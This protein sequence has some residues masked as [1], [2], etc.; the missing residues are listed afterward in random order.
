[1]YSG[2]LKVAADLMHRIFKNH[3]ILSQYNLKIQSLIF[4]SWCI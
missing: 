3:L 2:L 1:M 4:F